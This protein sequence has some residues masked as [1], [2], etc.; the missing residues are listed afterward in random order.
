MA[1]RVSTNDARG[2]AARSVGGNTMRFRNVLRNTTTRAG[3]RVD[4][5]WTLGWWVPPSVPMS[6]FARVG[7]L[8]S[9]PNAVAVRREMVAAGRSRF[10]FHM[11]EGQKAC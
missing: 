2:L 10:A 11:V 8:A 5:L 7:R 3:W 6:F 9:G 1:V 4:D